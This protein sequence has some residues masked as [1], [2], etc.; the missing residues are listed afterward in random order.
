MQ[1]WQAEQVLSRRALV[2]SL[3]ENSLSLVLLL[4]ACFV[5]RGLRPGGDSRHIGYYSRR[6][7]K[8][9]ESLQVRGLEGK[10]GNL[11]MDWVGSEPWK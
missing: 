8:A 7:R 6:V 4:F 3:G 11:I 10:L 1:G 2:F 5:R 9:L